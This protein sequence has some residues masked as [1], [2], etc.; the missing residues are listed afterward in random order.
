MPMDK[1]QVWKCLAFFR[2]AQSLIGEQKIAIDLGSPS[3]GLTGVFF[4]LVAFKDQAAHFL[5]YTFVDVARMELQRLVLPKVLDSCTYS[6]TE[7]PLIDP[8][9]GLCQYSIRSDASGERRLSGA[10]RSTTAR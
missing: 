7:N 8:R 3:L 10:A 6:T 5:G 4:P 1:Q 2:A 9:F